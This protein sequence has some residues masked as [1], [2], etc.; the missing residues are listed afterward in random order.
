MYKIYT[1][2]FTSLFFIFITSARLAIGQ[3]PKGIR[4]ID[5]ATSLYPVY[6]MEISKDG[7]YLAISCFGGRLHMLTIDNNVKVTNAFAQKEKIIWTKY[8]SNDFKWGGKPVFSPSSKHV[9]LKPLYDDLNQVKVK[10]TDLVIYNAENGEKV[11]ERI[12][13]ILSADFITDDLLLVSTAENLEWIDLSLKKVIEKRPMPEVETISVSEDGKLLAISFVPQPIQFA[14]L[15]S[16]KGRKRELKVAKRGKRLLAVYQL[17]EMEPVSVVDDEIDIVFGIKFS[18]DNKDLILFTRNF[19]RNFGGNKA[20]LRQENA[21]KLLLLN[22]IKVDVNTGE[23]DRNFYYSSS[24]LHMDYKL[25]PDDKLFAHSSSEISGDYVRAT[26]RFTGIDIYNY[27]YPDSLHSSVKTRFKYFKPFN[28]TYQCAFIPQ[29]T[30]MFFAFGPKLYEW[31][32]EQLRD[33]DFNNQG[34]LNDEIISLATQ[35]LDSLSNTEGFKKFTGQNKIEGLYTF[36][37]TVFKK[38]QVSSVF[39]PTDEATDVKAHNV[40]LEYVKALKFKD[41]EIPKDKRVKFQ[42]TFTIVP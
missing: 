16:I 1:F 25:S 26:K 20:N 38:G 41:L 3:L 4:E 36:D 14:R 33:F 6:G 10:P 27:Q 42:Y 12:N 31:D 40:M 24:H 30:K 23:L 13:E 22:L 39:S 28:Y 17:P 34:N 9:L 18:S 29:S 11:Y 5:Y 37:I 19:K 15:Q 35:Q 7:K 8:L 32:Y 21:Y 2:K